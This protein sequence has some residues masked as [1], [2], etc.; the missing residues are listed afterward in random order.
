MVCRD[1]ARG[2][3]LDI[4]EGNKEQANRLLINNGNGIYTEDTS[5]TVAVGALDTISIFVADVD[6]DGG[7]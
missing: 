2:A 7:A 5:S 3:D 4:L 1:C 6:G